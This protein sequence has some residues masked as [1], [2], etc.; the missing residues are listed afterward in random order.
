MDQRT[1]H[2][3][4]VDAA[5]RWHINYFPQ[6]QP[7]WALL[8]LKIEWISMIEVLTT[9]TAAIDGKIFHTLSNFFRSLLSGAIFIFPILRKRADPLLCNFQIDVS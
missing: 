5:D 3:C 7:F 6:Q 1:S 8:S 9:E 4:M 2:L